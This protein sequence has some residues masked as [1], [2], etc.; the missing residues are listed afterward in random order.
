MTSTNFNRNVEFDART[1][2]NFPE[3]ETSR[4]MG[5]NPGN[6]QTKQ[7]QHYD[8][9]SRVSGKTAAKTVV[10]VATI[11]AAI[12]LIGTALAS[13]P[14]SAPIAIGGTLL[15]VMGVGAPF[16]GNRKSQ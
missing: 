5:R 9:D 4:R 7:E 15:A 13:A 1:S 8:A 14:V 6:Y 16:M 10:T 3:D 2:V 11:A 12:P